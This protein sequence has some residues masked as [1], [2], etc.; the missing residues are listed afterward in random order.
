MKVS[1]MD[2]A[3]DDLCDYSDMNHEYCEDGDVEYSC[4]LDGLI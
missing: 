1:F 3:D 2:V 4:L